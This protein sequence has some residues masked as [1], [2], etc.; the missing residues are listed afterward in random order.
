ME[1]LLTLKDLSELIQVKRETIYKYIAEERI[2]VIRL[3]PGRNAL[4]RFSQV[5]IE[6]WIEAKKIGG[7]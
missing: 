5:D 1:K 6:E 7:R 3:G 2:P 4:L